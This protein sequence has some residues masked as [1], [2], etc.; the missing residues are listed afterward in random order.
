MPFNLEWD[1]ESGTY[2]TNR[3]RT[4]PPQSPSTGTTQ[5]DTGNIVG[6]SS[7]IAVTPATAINVTMPGPRERVI[8][9]SGNMA[10][11]WRRFFEELYRR[12]GAFEDNVN[13]T[14]RELSG[15]GT[16]IALAITG[17]APSAEITHIRDVG[18][19][20]LSFTGNVPTVV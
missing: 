13:T 4:G 10:P 14:S 20:S 6:D 8:D 5:A 11:R 16:T 19:G 7:T 12:T 18:V 15:S 17:Y 2:I 1:P 9:A 3:N